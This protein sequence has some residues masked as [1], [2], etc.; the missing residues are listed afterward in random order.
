MIYLFKSNLYSVEV[1]YEEVALI[2]GGSGEDSTKINVFTDGNQRCGQ[3]EKCVPDLPVPLLSPV[4]LYEG[5][6]KKNV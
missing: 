1:Q 5:G 4:A 2:I 3:S 6:I